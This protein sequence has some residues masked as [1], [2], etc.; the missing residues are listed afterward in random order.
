MCIEFLTRISVYFDDL[1]MCFVE[2]DLIVNALCDGSR[3]STKKKS[4]TDTLV[5]ILVAIL[6][7]SSDKYEN[8]TQTLV[9]RNKSERL[10]EIFRR[11]F[12]KLL[13]KLR[14]KQ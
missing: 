2:F 10:F 7:N 6:R 9:W 11:G 3:N 8:R 5:Y 4:M 14:I 1:F 13:Q 12:D